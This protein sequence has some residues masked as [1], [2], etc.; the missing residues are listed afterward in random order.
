MGEIGRG[1]WMGSGEGASGKLKNLGK[2]FFLRLAANSVHK[3][4]AQRDKDGITYARKDMVRTGMALNLNGLWGE[5]QLF[6]ELQEII[7]KHRN[8]FNGDSIE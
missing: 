2:S 8:H 7:A 5:K 3:V 4:N 6:S 1:S